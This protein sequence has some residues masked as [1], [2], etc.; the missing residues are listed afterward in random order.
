MTRQSLNAIR[1]VFMV[2]QKQRTEKDAKALLV[3]LSKD[4]I[5][6]IR[7][8]Q[9]ARAG[10]VPGVEVRVN[11]AM[12]KAIDQVGLPGPIE[13]LF[14]YRREIAEV[15]L[16]ALIQA[17]PR[18]SG[19]YANAHTVLLNGR[20]VPDLPANL[21]RGDVVTLVNPIVYARRIEIGKT[22]AG[23]K[24]VLQV[25]DRIYERVA[26]NVLMPRYRDVARI[27]FTYI[28]LEGAYI[29]KGKLASHYQIDETRKRGSKLGAAGT[30]KRRR[31]NQKPGT[32]VRYPAITIRM[33]R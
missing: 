24:F 29:T 6:R 26:K 33:K 11:G 7:T 31:R 16:V 30:K 14:D 3:R 9:A 15:G 5:A 23:R 32:P 17:S 21:G 13:A 28:D 10:I 12:G 4:G 8:T 1:Q 20:S 19:A 27:E 22:K 18:Q 25:P 2:D